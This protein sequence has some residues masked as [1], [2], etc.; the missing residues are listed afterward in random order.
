[1]RNLGEEGLHLGGRRVGQ[2][3]HRD[4]AGILVGDEAGVLHD[5]REARAVFGRDHG[6]LQAKLARDREILVWL[7]LLLKNPRDEHFERELFELQ[8]AVPKNDVAGPSLGIGPQPD[9]PCCFVALCPSAASLPLRRCSL[10]RC[11]LHPTSALHFGSSH[12]ALA[13]VHASASSWSM[14]DTS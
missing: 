1:M 8:H 6:V 9:T 7:L 12:V 3:L 10:C 4:M 14:A 13:G 2:F 5:G 11:A